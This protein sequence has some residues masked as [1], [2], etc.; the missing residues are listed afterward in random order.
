MRRAVHCIGFSL[1]LLTAAPVVSQDLGTPITSILTIDSERLFLNSNFGKRVARAVEARGNELAAENRQIEAELA[2]VEQELTDRRSTM[3]PEEFRP[4]AD[5]FDARVQETRAAQAAKSRE[6]SAMLDQ[7]RE[8]FLNAA[9]PVLQELMSEVGATV[10]LE[11]R[12]VFISS[13]SSDITSTA[14]DR[15]NNRL[16]EGTTPSQGESQD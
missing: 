11:R 4:L 6:L 9:G 1:A 7:E 8:V 10:I 14:I 16:G 12:T 3:T 2:A 15:L 5:D 13:N